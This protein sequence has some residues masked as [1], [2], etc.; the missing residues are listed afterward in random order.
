MAQRAKSVE[1]HKANGTYRPSRH[2]NRGL[3]LPAA[4]MMTAPEYLSENTKTAWIEIVYPLIQAGTVTEVDKA[5]LEDA[6]INYDNAQKCLEYIK[7]SGSIAHYL[8]SLNKIKNCNLWEEY[9][10]SMDKFNRIL[11]KF[12]VTPTE[13]ARIKMNPKKEGTSEIDL[14]FYELIKS[15][16]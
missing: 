10:K 9:N 11:I 16:G 1:E 5:I 14:F 6:F 12:G 13:R 3:T 2:A 4:E 15:G 7:K 8:Q